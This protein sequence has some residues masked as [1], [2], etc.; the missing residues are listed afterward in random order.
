MWK[1]VQKYFGCLLILFLLTG[2]LNV[3]AQEI[4]WHSFVYALSLADSTDRPILVDVG[5]PWCGWCHK[6]K[7]EVY[8]SLAADLQ[9]FATTRLNRDDHDKVYRYKGEK[10]SSF[11][12][13]QK[14]KAKAVPTIVFLTSN[15]DYLMH[16]SGF[17]EAEELR[18]V[19]NYITTQA[20]QDQT[21]QTFMDQVES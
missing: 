12:L 11:R 20:Y 1:K 13:A 16:L 21:F 18:P 15:G 19:L 6:M 8:P 7:Q 4:S 2:S 17:I 9:G 3:N 14:L 5:A 10:L